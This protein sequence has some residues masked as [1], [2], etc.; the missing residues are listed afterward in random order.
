MKILKPMKLGFG[1]A[2]LKLRFQLK[3]LEWTQETEDTLVKL[4]LYD[5]GMVQLELPH[6]G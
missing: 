5:A 1:I 6:V 2:I 3:G 4:A